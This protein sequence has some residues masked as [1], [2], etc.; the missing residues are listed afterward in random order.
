MNEELTPW[1]HRLIAN[2][3]AP[4]A[5]TRFE[6]RYVAAKWD[7]PRK[8]HVGH[9]YLG[10]G[11][12][13]GR[14]EVALD[15][16]LKPTSVRFF[17]GSYGRH[18]LIF[19]WPKLPKDPFHPPANGRVLERADIAK[20]LVAYYVASGLIDFE[21]CELSATDVI[22]LSAQVQDNLDYWEKNPWRAPKYVGYG[23]ER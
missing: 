22:E 10:R 2:A 19:E 18:E 17:K 5:S 13:N 15:K 1:R 4:R 7:T 9:I 11:Y 21:I 8:L 20:R 6:G 23:F 16:E 12:H 3:A 14:I